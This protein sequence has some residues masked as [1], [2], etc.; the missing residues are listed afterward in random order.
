MLADALINMVKNGFD[1][2]KLHIV[3]HSLGAQLSSMTSRSLKKKS[4]LIIKRI[5]ALD[6]AFPLF[7][8]GI[9]AGHLSKYDA[10]FVDVIHSD[11]F[12]YGAPISTGTADF[13]PNG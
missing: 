9:I 10:D 4:N 11:T 2:K 13:Y 6:P 1:I 7:Y 8:P 12:G 3:A 5:S